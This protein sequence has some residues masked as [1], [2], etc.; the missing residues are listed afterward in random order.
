MFQAS[1]ALFRKQR[2]VLTYYLKIK[3]KQNPTKQKTTAS[4]P[5]KTLTPPCP[6]TKK[7]P[8][9]NTHTPTLIVVMPPI[10][11]K[12]ACA[13]YYQLCVEMRGLASALLSGSLSSGREKQDSNRDSLIEAYID[14][15]WI[16]MT[17]E[18]LWCFL[19]CFY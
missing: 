14:I 16:L 1:N 11:I 15:P 19:Y 13:T 18:A 6:Q 2:H 12:E 10:D 4:P 3:T 8:K 5:K 7:I 9:T 17:S